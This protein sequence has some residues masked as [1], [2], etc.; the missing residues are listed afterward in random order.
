MNGDSK[1]TVGWEQDDRITPDSTLRQGDLIHFFEPDDRI[2]NYGIVVTADCD[3]E[4]KKHARLVT[5]VP[6]VSAKAILERYILVEECDSKIT[7][8]LQYACKAY[9]IDGSQPRGVIESMLQ[10]RIETYGDAAPV[11][12]KIA[13]KLCLNEITTMPTSDYLSLMKAVGISPK[14]HKSFA[15]KICARGDVLVLPPA[16]E[17]GVSA[18]IAWLRH[19][20][21]VPMSAIAIRTSEVRARTGERIARLASPF[22]YRLTQ[23]MA[24]VFSDIG[25]PN[26][27]CD[28]ELAV[29][30]ALTK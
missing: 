26:V 2:Q 29:Q 9:S 5:L 25:L 13:A 3:L 11:E 12:A 22:R 24:Q 17:F 20:W 7:C 14:G 1:S 19:I 10:T 8:M 4:Q 21:Q 23:K 6:V 28:M 16:E 18:H 15:D 30:E 27:D